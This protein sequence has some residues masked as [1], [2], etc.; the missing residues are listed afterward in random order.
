MDNIQQKNNQ[1]YFFNC[2]ITDINNTHNIEEKKI[3][4]EILQQ[5]IHDYITQT[6]NT[7]FNK[8]YKFL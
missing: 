2:I 7:K 5:I 8:N 6:Y 1:Q 3:K 4:I